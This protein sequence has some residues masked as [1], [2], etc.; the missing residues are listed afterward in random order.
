VAKPEYHSSLSAHFIG[1]L[2][3]AEGALVS[4]MLTVFLPC[5]MMDGDAVLTVYVY[6]V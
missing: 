5:L 6:S 4:E 1:F 3:A 2:T